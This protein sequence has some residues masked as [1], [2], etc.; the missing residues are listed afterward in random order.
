MDPSHSSATAVAPLP[1][2]AEQ[3]RVLSELTETLT[4]RLL[5]LEERLA[6]QELRVLPLL[7]GAGGDPAGA[8]VLQDEME[9]R[10]ED[11]EE[12][13]SRL[14]GVLS[15]L[16]TPASGAP[17]AASEEEPEAALAPSLEESADDQG[18]LDEEGEE[19]AYPPFRRIA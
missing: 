6:S 15:G 13:L 16:E 14:E 11:T 9:L 12:R 1:R 17:L 3:L 18:W 4:Y 10:L 8:A 5:E 7:E 19:Q 2:L